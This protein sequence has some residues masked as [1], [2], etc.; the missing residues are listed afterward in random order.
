MVLLV[1]GV[2]RNDILNDWRRSLPEDAPNYFLLNI[3]PDDWNGIAELFDSQ[4]GEVPD[5]LP[6]IRG[7]MSAINGVPIEELTFSAREVQRFFNREANMTWAA[8]LPGSNRVEAG[9]WW[10]EDYEGSLQL[11]IDAR[12]AGQMNVRIGDTISMTVGGE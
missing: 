4:L 8:A 2:V 1:L 11:S 3:E 10:G 7:R 6:L 12:M 9:E 5:F